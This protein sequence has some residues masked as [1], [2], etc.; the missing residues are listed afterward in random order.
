MQFPRVWTERFPFFCSWFGRGLLLL[1]IGGTITYIGARYDLVST[2]LGAI[3]LSVGALE[4]ILS[5]PFVH[6]ELVTELKAKQDKLR[7]LELQADSL[8]N[9]IHKLTTEAHRR[10]LEIQEREFQHQRE[11]AQQQASLQQGLSQHAMLEEGGASS[12]RKEG[13][14]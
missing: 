4:V 13:K 10:S 8:R 12:V 11:I 2:V 1:W 7:L 5:C 9:D 14:K 3:T 6:L